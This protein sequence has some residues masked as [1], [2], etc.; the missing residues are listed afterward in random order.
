MSTSLLLFRREKIKIK[1]RFQDDMESFYYII[2][3]ASI[4]L[5]PHEQIDD[6]EDLDEY[7]K[8][9][10]GSHGGTT[11]ES[12]LVALLR[13]MSFGTSKNNSSSQKLA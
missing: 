4:L 5:L 13:L 9:R 2:L 7:R 11:K 10:G 8:Y 3:Y 12:N 6:I 1:Y